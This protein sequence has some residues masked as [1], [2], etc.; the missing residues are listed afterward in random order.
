M[1]NSRLLP[2]DDNNV[3]MVEIYDYIWEYP[4]AEAF[5]RSDKVYKYTDSDFAANSESTHFIHFL[6]F[7]A[8]FHSALATHCKAG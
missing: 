2:R 1:A 3:D 4:I 7:A 6:H 5:D 8:E